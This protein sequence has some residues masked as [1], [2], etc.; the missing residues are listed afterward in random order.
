MNTAANERVIRLG[1][2]PNEKQKLFFRSRAR[3]TAYGGARGGGKSW[4]MRTK[5]VMLAAR[6][7][8]IQILL[9]RRT[10]PELRE[11]HVRP[12]QELLTGYAVYRQAGNEFLFPNGSRIRCGYCEAENDVYQY[13]GQAYDVIG[14]EEATL[15]TES[16]RDFIVTCNRPPDAARPIISPRMYYT[17][18]PGGV[19]HAW[20]KRLFIDKDYRESERPEDY[21]FIPATVYDNKY[22]IAADPD[23]VRQL[24][25]LPE[26]LRRAH[27]EGDW[28]VLAG[29]YFR[30]W[31]RGHHVVEPFAI[32]D[33]WQRF[34]SIDWG[35]NDPCAVYWHAV[36]PEG[37]VYTYRELYVRET[38]ASDVAKRVVSLSDGENVRYTAVSPDMW[39]KRGVR[40]IEG[41]SVAEIFTRNGVP[42]IRADNSREIGWTVMREFMADQSDGKPGWLVFNTCA[43]LI[44]TIPL[45]THDDHRVE[46]VSDHCEDHA[47]ESCRYA[48]MTRPRPSQKPKEKKI[49]PYNPLADP[50]RRRSFMSI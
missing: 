40:D 45:A 48:L 8:G 36:D 5:L 34:R 28:D 14:L 10:L 17:C 7:P 30:E 42:V 11:N 21:A 50:P 24:E 22:L 4:A 6:Y 35:Y 27:L 16:Q 25:N 13:Q 19:G 1:E 29:Q 2:E 46:D 9:M 20:V 31:R 41:E 23:Y 49:V 12:L 26:D 18:N 3:H 39:Q 15:F 47:L 32:P 43:N 44:R 37:R 38:M 33:W